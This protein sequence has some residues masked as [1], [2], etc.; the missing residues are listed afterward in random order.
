MTNK[1]LL[2]ILALFL[3]TTVFGQMS[4]DEDLGGRDIRYNP[5][6]HAAPFLTISPDSRSSGMGDVGVATTPD[7]YSSNWNI[8]KLA[9]IDGQTGIALGYTPWLKSLV[10]DIH[11]S[12]LT[13]YFRLDENQVVSGSLRYF[14]LGEIT[15]RDNTGGEIRQFIPNEFAIDGGYSR[16]LGPTFSMGISGRYMYSNLTGTMTSG[17]ETLKAGHAFA[18]DL[19]SYYHQDVNLGE[20]NGKVTAG[21]AFTNIGTKVT[22]SENNKNFLPMNLRLGTGLLIDLDQ[23]NS[24]AFY[25]DMNKLLVP[26][27]DP[28]DSLDYNRQNTSVAAAIFQSFSDAPGVN[29]SVF[30]EEIQE[31]MWSFGVEYLYDKKLAIRTG[32]F[33]ENARKG[34]RKYITAG[35]GFKLN[36]LSMDLSYLISTE[37]NHP[38]SKTLRFSLVL[39][40]G[41][42]ID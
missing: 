30:K 25:L 41:A 29:G 20:Y 4:D 19:G 35:A 39:D 17:S 14:S 36:V 38:L 8:G 37:A 32:Y 21:L 42:M 15:F 40:I 12:Y 7:A 18:V 2:S 10:N 9:N 5:I 34:N 31:I 27:P 24:I 6:R 23:Y 33:H 3:F 26:T 28:T 22:Y 11:L 1:L 16:R 13:G